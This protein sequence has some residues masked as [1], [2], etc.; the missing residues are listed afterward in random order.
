MDQQQFRIEKDSLGL[1]EVP[2]NAYYG[3]QT[4]RAK[5]NFAITN[6]PINKQMIKALGMIKL[7]SANANYQAGLIDKK[8]H[9]VITQAAYEVIEGK[10]DDYFITD[11]IQGGAG[12]SVNMNANEVIANRAA[13]LANKA[14]GVY[15]YIHPNDHI[16]FGQSTND[17]YPSAGRLASLFLVAELLEQLQLLQ[18]SLIRKG[19]QFENIL[20]MGRTHL[21]DAIPIQLGQEFK[22]F[23][24]S[25]SRDIKRI[26]LAFNDLKAVNMGATAI[27]TGL[28]ADETYKRLIVKELSKISGINLTSAKDLVDSTRNVDTFVWAHSA[29][30]TLAVNI[31]KMSNDLRL[32]ASGP[33]TGFGEISLPEK[34]PGSSIMP[35][36]VNPVIAE[37]AN[38]VCFN[39]FGND[40]TVLKA[41]EAGQLELNVFEP[42]MFYK[43]FESIET[44]TNGL[45]TLRVNAIDDIVA[46]ETRCNELVEM[47]IGSITAIAPHIGYANASNLAKIALLEKRKLRDVILESGL[48]SEKELDVI[49]KPK[50]LTRPGIAGKH[51]LAKKIKEQHHEN[52]SHSND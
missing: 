3:A 24:T 12:T 19:E 29:L 51:L 40:V 7:A 6:R 11:A 9:S 36:K 22:A 27:G 5:S 8:R 45:Y 52:D 13:Q 48:L 41:A 28:N 43:I 34:Q 23:A 10:L 42:V 33:I 15:D 50:S 39:V 38:Q 30:K 35:G 49:L 17:V 46:N 26:K 32:M 18:V 20:K 1:V 37:V 47:S 25:L 16:N 4:Q 14:M 44:L 2:V 31:S 21:Q